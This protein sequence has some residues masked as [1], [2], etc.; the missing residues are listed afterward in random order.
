MRKRTMYNMNHQVA[1]LGDI[2][3]VVPFMFQ[4]IAP[5]DTWSGQ[6]KG[7]LRFSP[8]KRAML[9]DLYVDLIVAYVPHRL[10]YADWEDFIAE[11]PVDSPTY[12]LPTVT[13][14]A[15]NASFYQSIFWNRGGS[16]VQYCALRLYAYNLF[17]NE[18]ILDENDSKRNPTD[19]PG[20][21][22]TQDVARAKRDYWTTLNDSLG[23]D[24]NEQFFDTNVGSGTQASAQDVLD[25]IARQKIQ[26]KRATYGSRYIDILRSYG[27]N[28]NYQMLQR[29]EIV[30]IGRTKVGFTDVVATDGAN[31]GDMAGHGIS[32]VSLRLR[33]KS[34]PEHGMLLG[35]CILR[36]KH[37]NAY[38]CDWFDRARDYTSFYDPGLVTLPHVAVQE[39]DIAPRTV[40]ATVAG[41]QPWGEWYRRALSRCHTGLADNQW[42]A[43]A[44]G[45][46]A[47]ST[48]AAELRK[49]L[50]PDGLF[51]DVT[52]QQWQGMFS[53]N[54]RAVRM[55][56]RSNISTTATVNRL[57]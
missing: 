28:V 57:G 38:N 5:G 22:G 20:Q 14:N 11:G 37:M 13:L 42:I 3:S 24:Q 41:Y 54:L 6:I 47:G 18:Y 34:F 40:S 2:C 27:I 21:Y 45:G 7:L 23:F 55:I 30:G 50:F 51:N 19:V 53:N 46:S 52:Y 29:P 10:V 39:Q 12:S 49:T 43:L 56:P 32:G 8:L 31:L 9:Q 17:L 25:A 4:E 15:G 44:P 35:V 48:D 1:T 16:D 26:L 33:R 36:P